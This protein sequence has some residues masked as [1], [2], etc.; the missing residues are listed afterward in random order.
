[1]AGQVATNPEGGMKL[2]LAGKRIK[3]CNATNLDIIALV[4][5]TAFP[6]Q[7]V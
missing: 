5:V 2:L 1:L 6:E 7:P 3:K 4:I